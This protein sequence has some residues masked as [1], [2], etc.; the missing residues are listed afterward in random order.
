MPNSLA[1]TTL[2]HKKKSRIADNSIL[3]IFLLSLLGSIQNIERETVIP[4]IPITTLVI[5]TGCSFI[6]LITRR[7]NVLILK[8]P[9]FIGINSFGLLILF[10]TFYSKYPLLTASRALQFIIVT[11]CLYLTLSHIDDLKS[12]FEKIAKIIIIFT[13]IACL[14]GIIIYQFGTS[15]STHGIATTGIK[16]I[17]MEL[18]QRMYGH[19]ISSFLGNPNPFGVRIMVS[20][21][22]C[23]YFL[24]QYNDMR[25][26]LLMIIFL[27]ALILT[28]SRASVAG[29]IGGAAI[30]LNYA[31]LK[32]NLG[33]A[34]LRTLLLGLSLITLGYL[35]IDPEV[36]KEVFSLMG[37]KSNTLSGREIA[38]AAL[39]EQIKESPYLGIG[40]R[41]STEAILKDNF[42]DVSNSHN[43][44]L[45]ILSEIGLIGFLLFIYLYIT[46]TIKYFSFREKNE[47][48]ILKL[49]TTCILISL[50]INQFFEDMFSPLNFFFIWSFFI[51]FVNNKY[52]VTHTHTHTRKGR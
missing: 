17:G 29:L 33:A 3:M 47:R 34:A 4:F 2:L 21:L 13:L 26:G 7:V 44:Y 27:Y 22:A 18:N 36:I 24:R 30:F 25:Y 50:L 16:F 49:A 48:S 20:A 41:I 32:N 52:N 1:T 39:M 28:G 12:L 19:R 23:L 8:S 40:Y 5:L 31:Y 11:N 45:S 37:R 10:S 51:L 46:P 15:Y 9:L 42:I 35:L 14:Y 6:L 38:W 43:L